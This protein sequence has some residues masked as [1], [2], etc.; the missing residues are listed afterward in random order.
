MSGVLP[1]Y[2]GTFN[3][4]CPLHTNNSV[5]GSGKR[6]AHINWSMDGDVPRQHPFGTI[7]TLRFT[8]PVPVDSR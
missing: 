3:M 7:N 2:A 5:V 6:E 4:S 8:G 1:V